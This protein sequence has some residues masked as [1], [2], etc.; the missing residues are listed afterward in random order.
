[1]EQ[2]VEENALKQLEFYFSDSALQKDRFL[3]RKIEESPDSSVE[4][5]LVATFNKLRTITT[6]RAVL[7]GAIKK[8]SLLELNADET[9]VKRK[10]PLPK[11]TNADSR[12]VYTENFPLD[13]EHDALHAAFE[14]V[15]PVV[16]TSLPRFEDR[17]IKGFAFV[18][19]QNEEDALK[20][21]VQLNRWHV[22]N[23][24]EDLRVM[25]KGDWL[26]FRQEY[27]DL[28]EQQGR[29]H[30]GDETDA[31]GA[32]SGA[33]RGGRGRGGRGEFRGG[34]RPQH[35]RSTDEET[36]D[37]EAAQGGGF[38]GGRGGRGDFRGGR[39]GRGDFRGGRGGAAFPAWQH[40][41]QEIK[42]DSGLILHV[43]GLPPACTR[44]QLKGLFPAS[45]YVDFT[46]SRDHAHIRFRSA[47][48]AQA[49]AASVEPARASIS[50]S[51][52]LKILEGE[53]ERKYFDVIAKSIK[54]FQ[55]SGTGDDS[56]GQEVQGGWRGRGGFRGGDRGGRGD[57]GDRGGWRGGQGRGRDEWRGDRGGRGRGR[58]AWRGADHAG[59]AAGSSGEAAPSTAAADES[60]VRGR[61]AAVI[62]ERGRHHATLSVSQ[63]SKHIR[64]D[65]SDDDSGPSEQS[66]APPAVESNADAR[67]EKR[68]AAEASLETD[69]ADNAKKAK[70]SD[71]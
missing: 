17:R 53:D 10:L 61:D 54:R 65:D 64:F 62:K 27:R 28:L 38:R 32:P 51:V 5:D 67:P 29:L 31:D 30:H 57:R 71:A 69:A 15:G 12:T 18:E 21:V 55:E 33:H 35:Q 1:M 22:D 8:S 42:M 6:D 39:G 3:Q 59:A 58:G 26:Q 37:G 40:A 66:S 34:Q 20:A 13:W 43:S 45:A 11:K 25:S 60:H 47:Q 9:R 48:D 36:A 14:V 16:Y 4:L 56:G 41:P 49:A 70:P 24:P 7:V 68:K 19:Y 50:P 46:P 23:K 44:P 63:K 52:E 2:D